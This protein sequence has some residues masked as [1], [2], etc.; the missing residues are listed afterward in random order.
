MDD[1]GAKVKSS[2]QKQ[3]AYLPSNSFECQKI[4]NFYHQTGLLEVEN[5]E[6]TINPRQ[7]GKLCHRETGF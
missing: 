3:D 5:T 4:H 1:E 2:M 6:N 7:S